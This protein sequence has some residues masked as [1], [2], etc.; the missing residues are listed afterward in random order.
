[1]EV[2]ATP[3]VSPSPPASGGLI[4]LPPPPVLSAAGYNL[5]LEFE[6]GGRSGY[7]PHPEWPKGSSGVT[8]GIGYDLGYNSRAVIYSDWNALEPVSR[9]RLLTVAGYTGK[10]ARD[11][12]HEVRDIYVE[13]GIATGVFDDVDLAREFDNA[14]RS[15]PG[16]L[17]LRRN[18]QAALISLGFNRGWGMLGGNRVEMR[19][20][21]DVG[22]PRQDYER[23]AA[24]LRQ[25]TR[26]W[27]GTEIERGMTRRRN[28][29]AA[30]VE[31]P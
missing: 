14:R 10:R 8:I 28:A 24:Q 26:I 31:T 25:M 7:D 27:R 3:T 16:F 6:T 2:H 9:T 12:L 22:V 5:I 20:I 29:E 23:I 17:S 11:I 30:L 18:A 13:W 21:R 15:M 1:V 19:D 4:A